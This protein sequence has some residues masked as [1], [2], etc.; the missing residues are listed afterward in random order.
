MALDRWGRDI[1][2]LRVSITDR[3]NLRCIYCMP[4]EGIEKLPRE[5]LLTF[6]EIAQ[7]VEA[8]TMIGVE[9]VRITG[10]EPLVRRDVDVLIG[11]IRR[12]DGI[13]EIALTTNGV[14]LAEWAER[15]AKAGLDR[16]NVSLD[17]MRDD[18]YQAITRSDVS[19]KE[20]LKGIGIAE[21]MGLGPIKLNV[22]LMKGIND[23]EVEDFA[24]LTYD[25]A[26]HIR[27]IELMPFAFSGGEHLVRFLSEGEAAEKLSWMG[28]EPTS[29]GGPHGGPARYYRAK[30]ALGLIGFI[31]PLSHPFCS[32]CNRIRLSSDGR[33]R[34]CLVS[35]EMIDLRSAVRRGVQTADLAE[36]MLEAIGRKP[37]GYTIKSGEAHTRAM[38]HIG[39]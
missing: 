29:E 27:F 7:I 6:E 1:N 18:R 31:S 8:A 20:V 30:G 5:E 39:G 24:R 17:S 2:Y 25:R 3:C 34:T 13:R 37:I 35:D 28:L 15:L 33:L 21:E 32:G 22:V 23:D 11:M 14:R 16:I 12:I 36:R 9:K 4:S 26:W 10:G 38:I 19:P